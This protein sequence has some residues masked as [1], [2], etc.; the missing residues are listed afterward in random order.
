MKLD[1]LDKELSDTINH[2]NEVM[3]RVSACEKC[4]M[5]CKCGQLFSLGCKR[6]SLLW[7]LMLSD[8]PSLIINLIIV[9]LLGFIIVILLR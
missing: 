2:A 5:R 1:Q 7:K 8:R 4:P 9:A 3:G 6:Q